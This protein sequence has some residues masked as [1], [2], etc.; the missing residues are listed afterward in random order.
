MIESP[1]RQVIARRN[2][3][4]ER[5]YALDTADDVVARRVPRPGSHRSM[6]REPDVAGLA[7]CLRELV[8]EVLDGDAAGV[9][10]PAV[11]AAAR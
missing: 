7:A 11:A 2:T 5:W 1:P 3:R 6:M 4:L 8:D 10:E 9:G